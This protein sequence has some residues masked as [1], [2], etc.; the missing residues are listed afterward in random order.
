M[1]FNIQVCLEDIRSAHNVGSVFRTCE[2]AGIDKLFLSGLSAHPPHPKLEKTA[3]GSSK[4]V[5]WEYHQDISPL[6][7]RL[8]KENCQIIA[9]ELTKTAESIYEY[10]LN[11]D[12]C[13][14]FG[15]EVHGVSSEVLHAS[16]AVL[17][18]PMFG[19]KDSLNV[20]VAAGISIYEFKRKQLSTAP[21]K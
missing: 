9:L 19:N 13:L 8:K 1:S 15:N 3:L 11:S 6:L 12:I 20:S 21:T 5:K 14:F 2:S 16:D 4:D 7:T 18:I 10:Q 17:K